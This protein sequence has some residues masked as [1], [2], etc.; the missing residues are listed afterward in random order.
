MI[1]C[2]IKVKNTHTKS[3]LD[4]I[5]Y[6]DFD[7]VSYNVSDLYSKLN[8]NKPFTFL[9]YGETNS[10]KSYTLHHI[11]SMFS[12]NIPH[13]LFSCVEIYNNE[14][15][16]ITNG[17][18]KLA[19][20]SKKS[21]LHINDFT[22]FCTIWNKLQKNRSIDNNGHN[23]FSSRSH[24]IVEIKTSLGLYAFVDLA[25]TE[26]NVNPESY[27]INLSLYCLRDCVRA[28]QHKEVVP[29]RRS[30]LT[31]CMQHYLHSTISLYCV[32]TVIPGHTKQ[33][34]HT[35]EYGL[36]MK[37]LRLR[38]AYSPDV[39]A[40]LHKFKQHS[41]KMYSL[42]LDM[43]DDYIRNKNSKS[44]SFLQEMMCHYRDTLEYMIRI[45][46]S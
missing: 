21:V 30:K 34:K 12:Q 9:V 33:N 35:L 46:A 19:F 4:T 32:C 24:I 1:K 11:L 31:H 13:Y 2:Y 15:Y 40:E 42:Q 27:H 7:G 5:N 14:L 39:L 29:Y 37:G 10:G 45:L 16:D 38:S 20:Y 44:L 17:R 22:H 26:P 25:G 6:D 41:K 8:H 18:F 28:L 3:K 23:K 43:V 36:S